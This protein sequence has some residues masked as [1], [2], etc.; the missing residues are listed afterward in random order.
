MTMMQAVSP[1]D[2]RVLGDYETGTPASIERQIEMARVA[3]GLWTGREIATR[4]K[5]LTQIGPILLRELDEI[6]EIIMQTTGKVRTEAL[7][8]EI[9]P[10]LDLIHYYQKHAGSYLE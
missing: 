2:G 10:V 8:G 9:Y 5:T 3:A 1:I 7:L 6:V 4:A